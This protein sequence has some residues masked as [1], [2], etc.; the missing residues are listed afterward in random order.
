MAIQIRISIALVVVSAV[1]VA[2]DPAGGD[3]MPVEQLAP[4]VEGIADSVLAGLPDGVD[5]EELAEGRDLYSTCSV[6][7][8]EDARGTQL[9]PS[10]RGPEW[11]HIGGGIEEIVAISR[12]GVSDPR[13]HPVPMP[14]MGGGSF[15]DQQLRAIAVYLE[16]L[17]RSGR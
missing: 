16:A 13:S 9:G 3:Q 10:L 17:G 11:I 14:P 6:C 7:H 2:C 5:Q 1:A 8:G 15:D 12:S 4:T